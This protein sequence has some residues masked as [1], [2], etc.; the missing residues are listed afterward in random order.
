MT[1]DLNEKVSSGSGEMGGTFTLVPEGDID[2][3]TGILMEFTGKVE[4]KENKK[5]EESLM[6]EAN[7][8]DDPTARCSVF[9]KLSEQAGL[10]KL[11]DI[12]TLSG[13]DVKIKRKRPDFD[14]A[15]L[16][17]KLLTNPKFHDQLKNDI[18]GCSILATVNHSPGTDK[19]GNKRIYANINRIAST[20]LT[21]NVAAKPTSSAGTGG[22]QKNSGW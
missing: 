11:V 7:Y 22:S 4:I 13:V 14:S 10:T 21:N 6:V 3:G 9:C 16:T 17:G 12:I 20:T 8:I 5:G 15:N 1:V 19:E 18:Q 2:K